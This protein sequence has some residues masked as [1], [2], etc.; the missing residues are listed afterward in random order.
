MNMNENQKMRFDT[1]I[2]FGNI[3][4]MVGM[5]AA[6]LMFVVSIHFT[7]NANRAEIQSIKT[8]IAEINY[9]MT[10]LQKTVNSID[11]RLA[12]LEA[13]FEASQRVARPAPTL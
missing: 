2:T 9:T 8:S 10:D 3:L 6:I 11:K 13:R 5:V 12:V 7:T 4:T 1:T